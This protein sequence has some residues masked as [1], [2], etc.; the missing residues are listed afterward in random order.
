MRQYTS[1]KCRGIKKLPE[2]NKRR[3][4]AIQTESLKMIGVDT[5]LLF[6]ALHTGMEEYTKAK[7][8]L[9]N[10]SDST[11]IVIAELVLMEVYQL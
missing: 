7:T 6:Y 9:A 11:E 5:N 1:H 2:R 8:I 3:I 4:L 10:W